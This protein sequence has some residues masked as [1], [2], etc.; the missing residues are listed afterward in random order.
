MSYTIYL[1]IPF[2][3]SFLDSTL[4]IFD[5]IPKFDQFRLLDKGD[6]AGADMIIGDHWGFWTFLHTY[7]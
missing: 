4:L 7:T 3:S 6:M 2:D 5:I 1:L